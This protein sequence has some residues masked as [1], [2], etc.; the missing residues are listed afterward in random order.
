MVMMMM[1]LETVFTNIR[2]ENKMLEFFVRS[3]DCLVHYP[4]IGNRNK[5]IYTT[6]KELR[7]LVHKRE[8]QFS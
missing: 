2:N 4:H 6:V 1:R 7:L 8:M 3:Y 5:R